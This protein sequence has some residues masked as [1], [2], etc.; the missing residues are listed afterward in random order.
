MQEVY[1]E[2]KDGRIF[3]VV[4]DVDSCGRKLPGFIFKKTFESVW[5]RSLFEI[6]ARDYLERCGDRIFKEGDLVVEFLWNCTQTG[7]VFG[8]I[9]E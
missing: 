1:Y 3:E 2:F 5:K 8:V 6:S 9:G 7:D 4:S